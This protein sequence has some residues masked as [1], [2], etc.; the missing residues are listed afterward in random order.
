MSER[1]STTNTKRDDKEYI[2]IIYRITILYIYIYNFFEETQKNIYVT[3]SITMPTPTKVCVKRLNKELRNIMKNPIP[4]LKTRPLAE[5]I[6]EWHYVIYNL[7]GCYK[8]GIYHGVLKFPSDYPYKPPSLRMITPSGRFHINQKLCLSFTDFHPESWNPMW[9]VST[10]LSGLVSFFLEESSHTYGSMSASKSQRRKF[11]TNSS[12]FNLRDSVFCDLF[13]DM[14]TVCKE[15]IYK[16]IEA[17]NDN[18]NS[19]NSTNNNNKKIYN[20]NNN[21]VR[22]RG[23]TGNLNNNIG[24]NATPAALFNKNNLR[25]MKNNI[26]GVN[27]S[28]KFI[29]TVFL[30]LFLIC[31]FGVISILFYLQQKK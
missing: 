8:D 17:N 5:N 21:P 15:N 20:N 26:D 31:I 11:A 22:R 2:Y 29:E 1:R 27:R 23:G 24:G 10:I 13:P 30:V 3:V 12:T 28:G 18:N 7:D 25:N 14:A 4:Q 9:S 19:N 6:L 16:S